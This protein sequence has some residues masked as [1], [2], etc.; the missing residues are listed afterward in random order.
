MSAKSSL[1]KRPFFILFIFTIGLYVG[2]YIANPTQYIQLNNSSSAFPKLV[3]LLSFLEYNYVDELNL[4]SL[5][6]EIITNTLEQLDP[7]STYIHVDELQ[8]ITEEM[9]GNFDGIGVE[10]QIQHD[11]IVVV[12]PISGGPSKKAGILSGDRIVKVDTLNVAGVGFTNAD[13]V[14]NLRGEKG[15]EVKLFIKRPNHSKLLE[16]TI[17]RDK[18]PI[19][20]V[21]VSYMI[22]EEIGYIKVNR[23]SGTTDKEFTSAIDFL[24]SNGMEKLILDLRSNP[25][26]YLHAATAMVDEFLSHGEIVYTQGNSRSKKIYEASTYG[27]FLKQDVIVLVDEGSASASEIVAG[28]LQDHD[29]ATIIGRR[30]FG[31]GLVQE[32][33]Q[34]S[35]GSAFRLTT[36]R[37][38][39]PSGRSIQKAYSNDVEAYHLETVKRY[40]NGELYSQDSI[41][42]SD[43][44]KFYT[45]NGRIV[46]GGGGIAPDYF[47]PLDTTGRS[48][49]LFKVLAA[50]IISGFVFDFVAAN[51]ALLNNYKNPKDFASNFIISENTFNSF[52]ELCHEKNI[53]SNKAQ[54]NRSK[55]WIT[56]RLRTSIARHKWNDE[57]FFT[58][59]NSSDRS[60]QKGLELLK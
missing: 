53:P 17:V 39:T 52:L 26:G 30:T 48:D 34:M 46:Y 56:K 49:W 11:T 58:V 22:D 45:D 35:D 1:L 44:L 42:I 31:K 14:K 15:T 27:G 16:F 57:G 5:Q 9:Q 3:E 41:K 28:A 7:H 21:D 32:Q 54:I 36:A 43:S 38:Y 2:K 55:Q 50:N 59:L 13:V 6:E 8:S 60:V 10:F 20:S 12:S 47:V 51:K 18:I 40:E 25:G 4:D 23:F 33:T 19:T 29:R 24:K 37:Y